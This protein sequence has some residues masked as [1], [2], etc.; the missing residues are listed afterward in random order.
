M[1]AKR[2]YVYILASKSRALYIGMTGFLTAR[3]LQHKAGETDGFTRRYSINRLV[4]F[5]PFRYVNN[6]LSRETYLKTWSRKRKV[7]LIEASNPLWDDLAEGWGELAT[8]EK[9]IPTHAPAIAQ[10]GSE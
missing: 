7:A 3:I 8:A 2:Y 10:R 9:Q 6:A 5:E 4:Y 1:P